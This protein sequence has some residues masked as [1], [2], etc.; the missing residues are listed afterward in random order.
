MKKTK[1]FLLALLCVLGLSAC[2][3]KEVIS[4]NDQQVLNNAEMIASQY[5][6]PTLTYFTDG[7]IEPSALD[8]YT[9]DALGIVVESAFQFPANGYAF[10]SASSSPT[11]IIFAPSVTTAP[12]FR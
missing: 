11:A 12:F 2:G 9:N 8:L 5:V 3:S 4:E 1:A 6:V 7:T 10:R